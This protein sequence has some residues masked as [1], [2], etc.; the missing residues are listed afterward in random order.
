MMKLSDNVYSRKNRAHSLYLTMMSNIFTRMKNTLKHACKCKSKFRRP[1]L[2]STFT[3]FTGYTYKRS[4]AS[5]CST[6]VNS[7]A[8]FRLHKKKRHTAKE[9]PNSVRSG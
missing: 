4:I 2:L 7:R 5:K 9:V 1:M 6:V 3:L 8:K